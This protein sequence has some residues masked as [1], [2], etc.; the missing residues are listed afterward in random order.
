MAHGVSRQ[1][2]DYPSRMS[3]SHRIVLIAAVTAACVALP[4]GATP[5]SAFH[6]GDFSAAPNPGPY[7][8]YKKGSTAIPGWTVT[9]ATV[10]LIGTYWVAPGKLRSIDMDGTPGFG[11]IA[12]T[13][14]T[15]PG[16]KYDVKFLLSGNADAGPPIKLLRV[17]AAGKHA[18]Y[19]F[20]I[21]T[22]SAQR[23]TWVNESWSFVATAPA[24]TLQFASMDTTGG[25]CGPVI[26]AISVALSKN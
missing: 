4:A 21:S 13:F 26:A 23:G 22:G 24:T 1:G 9:K 12:Q 2:L 20:D 14:A 8:T 7:A 18:D 19:T 25:E 3:F 16:K 17:S 6:D 15:T 5:P 11:A 10:D